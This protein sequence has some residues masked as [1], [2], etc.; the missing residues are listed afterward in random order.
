MGNQRGGMKLLRATGTVLLVL[1]A[2]IAFFVLYELV[3]TN[4]ATNR[5][6]AALARAFASENADDPTVGA[7]RAPALG[8]PVARI[9]IPSIG[10]DKI[11]VEGTGLPQLALGPGHYSRTPLPG[12][13]G[14]VGIA[15]HRTTH[16]APFYDI[17]HLKRGDVILIEM[18]NRT[19]TYRVTAKKIVNPK[20][21]W[22][23]KGDPASNATS[24]LTLTTCT[25][26]FS[27]AHRLVVWADQVSAT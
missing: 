7:S 13:P 17:S 22:V 8:R 21:D 1:G 20:D 10:V 11:V 6:Q 23:L 26:R 19:F 3:G 9:E 25:P 24:K 5:H 27:A 18:H 16:G 4:M 12:A 2:T 14:V 15:G